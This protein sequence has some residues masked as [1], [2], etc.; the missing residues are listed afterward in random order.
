MNIALEVGLGEDDRKLDARVSRLP[1]TVA[2]IE[3]KIDE[4]LSR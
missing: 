3:I 4:L 1:H 2:P